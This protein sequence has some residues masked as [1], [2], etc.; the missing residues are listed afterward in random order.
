M[1]NG[2]KKLGVSVLAGA[3]ALTLLGC[4]NS[5]SSSS[6]EKVK[7]TIFQ[8]KVESNKQFKQIAARY[9]KLHPNVS[10]SVS[11]V[12]GGTDYSPV[13]K[14]R[15]SSGN[16]PTIF[17]LAGPAD[18]KQFASQ[19]ADLS[20]TKAAKAAQPGTLSAVKSNGKTVGLPFNVEG[21]GFVYNK[22]IF[23]EAGIDATKL[24]TMSKLTAAVKKIDSQKSKLGIKGVFALPGK[25]TWIL[26]DHLANL[27]V[28]QQFKGN[29]L[30]MYNSKSMKFTANKE[31]KDMIDLQKQYSVGPVMQLDYSAQVNQNFSQ[32]KVAMIQQGDWIYPTVEQ[33]D[34][35]FAQN[36]IG[37]IPIPVKGYENKLPVGTSLYWGVNKNKSQAEQKAAKDFLDWMYTSKEGKKLVVNKLHFVPAYK[38]YSNMKMKD[39][40]SQVD[41]K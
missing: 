12:G 37:M 38:G 26:S 28:G 40:L 36:D 27:Y 39:A 6:D 31:M 15:I 23:K 4:S 24:T 16:A 18:V 33:I 20:N 2:W 29:A 22:K 34:K 8:G 25:E 5:N 41:F 10:I 9:H 3:M 13:L 7:I 1:T 32:G 19:E 21:Y 30:K 35:K 17:S 14:T 11:S